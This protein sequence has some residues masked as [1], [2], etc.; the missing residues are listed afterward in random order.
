[1]LVSLPVAMNRVTAILVKTVAFYKTKELHLQTVL[2]LG[3]S[4]CHMAINRLCRHA[5]YQYAWSLVSQSVERREEYRSKLYS[6]CYGS[7]GTV[8]VLIQNIPVG[9][10]ND[11]CMF[12]LNCKSYITNYCKEGNLHPSDLQILYFYCSCV[13]A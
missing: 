4:E 9:I 2:H 1:V 11:R 3:K 5:L 7:E 8:F 6:S 10:S 13:V 12:L